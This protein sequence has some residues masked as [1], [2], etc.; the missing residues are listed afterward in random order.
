MIDTFILMNERVDGKD[1]QTRF[2]NALWL[3][4]LRI[5]RVLRRNL[6]AYVQYI[7]PMPPLHETREKFGWFPVKQFTS[8]G[9]FQY[10]ERFYVPNLHW[11]LTDST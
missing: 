9:V 1:T 7:L 10:F 8:S 3:L 6:L 11:S 5:E 4:L 2:A